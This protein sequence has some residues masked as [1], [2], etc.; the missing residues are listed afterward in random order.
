MAAIRYARARN[1]IPAS[2]TVSDA[3]IVVSVRR[4]FFTVG[5][6]KALTP[7]LTASTP[8]MAVQPL[9]NA[10]SRSQRPTASVGGGIGGGG[11]IGTGCPTAKSDFA[12][13][14]P[15]AITMQKRKR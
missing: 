4:A 14:T 11:T 1:A 8:V 10:F 5:S 9:A 13:P 12:T 7:L 6:R 2:M 3:M 15:M